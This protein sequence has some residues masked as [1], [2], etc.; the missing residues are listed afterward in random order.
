M[1]LP[2]LSM[3]RQSARG[4]LEE[5]YEFK[6]GQHC[7][8]KRCQVLIRLDDKRVVGFDPGTGATLSWWIEQ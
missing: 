6:D 4:R 3:Q 8:E 7:Q 1:Y 5:P 2:A